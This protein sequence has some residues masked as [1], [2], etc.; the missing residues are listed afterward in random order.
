MGQAGIKFVNLVAGLWR[1]PLD[2]L[3]HFKHQEARAGVAQW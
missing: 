2:A 1:V 3:L